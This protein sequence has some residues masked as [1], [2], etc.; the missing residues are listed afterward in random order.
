MFVI[1][2]NINNKLNTTTIMFVKVNIIPL[3]IHPFLA[4]KNARFIV[5]WPQLYSLEY[6][7]PLPNILK[8]VEPLAQ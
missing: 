5:F 6:Q 7:Y 3:A 1:F 4:N 8:D 2:N